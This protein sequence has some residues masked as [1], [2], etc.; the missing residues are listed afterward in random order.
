MTMLYVPVDKPVKFPV[1]WK[2]TPLSIEYCN[3][4]VPP[5]AVMSIVPSELPHVDCATV[6]KAVISGFSV[7]TKLKFPRHPLASEISTE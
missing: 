2:V 3:G 6:N 1:T 5:L 7:S 4:A